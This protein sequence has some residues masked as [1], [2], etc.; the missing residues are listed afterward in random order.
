MVS[1]RTL[2]AATAVLT[3]AFGAAIVV[4]SIKAGIGWTPRGVGSGTFPSI[5]GVLIVAASLY[6]LVRGLRG[7]ATVVLDGVGARKLAALFVPAA[8]FVAAIPLAGLHVA[9][10]AYVLATV[11]F[12]AKKPL[13][14]A[15][16]MAVAMPL[17]LYGIFDWAF[18]LPL[19]RGLLGAAL[20]F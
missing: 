20:G 16:L 17:A 7:P 12:Q 18:Q 4:S 8:L 15:A 19:P 2:E 11:G 1:Q 3:G 10:A 9:A 5:A 6:N 13:W 14:K